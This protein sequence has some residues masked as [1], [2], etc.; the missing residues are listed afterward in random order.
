M[1]GQEVPTFFSRSVIAWSEGGYRYVLEGDGLLTC[2]V[3]ELH[4]LRWPYPVTHARAPLW[5]TIFS[6][7]REKIGTFAARFLVYWSGG[8]AVLE[9]RLRERF[10]VKY[11]NG[12]R[13]K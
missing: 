11:A 8:G 6:G 3:A 10:D 9:L 13:T 5:M 1:D 2:G 12:E 4:V 7:G